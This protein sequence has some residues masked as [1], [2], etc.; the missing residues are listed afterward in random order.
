MKECIFGLSVGVLLGALL[1]GN[2][3]KAQEMIDKGTKQVK[4][5]VSKLAKK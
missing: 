3:P 1:V 4:E 2:S 5:K